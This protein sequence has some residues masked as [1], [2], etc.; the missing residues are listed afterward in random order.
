[1]CRLAPLALL[2]A[3]LAA[4]CG[5]ERTRVPD[6]AHALPP[7]GFTPFAVPGTGVSFDRPKN[8][9]ELDPAPPLAGGVR[10][11]TATVAVWR[12]PRAEPLPRGRS[13]LD[14][15][16]A[17]LLDRVRARN[18]TFAVRTSVVTHLGGARG[19]ELTGRQR[20]GGFTYDVRSA[21]L[22]KARA[23]VVIDAYAPPAD[24]ARVDATVFEPLLRSLRVTKP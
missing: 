1:M 4:G 22:F 6:V 18:P 16:R 10:S 7:A 2:A 5:E 17:R 23:E 13:A 3:L 12:Y 9:I 21:H 20:I 14:Q 24:F 8:W 15:A 19:I 11:R